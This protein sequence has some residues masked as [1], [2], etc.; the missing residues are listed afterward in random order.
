MNADPFQ[1]IQV[2]RRPLHERIADEMEEM[3]AFHQLAPGT[4][5]PTERE[6]AQRLDV[7]RSTVHQAIGLL[8]QRGLVGMKVGSGTYVTS[9]PASVVA[10]SIQRYFLFASCSIADLIKLRCILEPSTAALAAE[11]ATDEDLARLEDCVRQVEQAYATRD[12][13][14]YARADTGFHEALAAASHNAL[15]S[16]I[17]KGLHALMCKWLLEHALRDWMEEGPKT[18]R[19]VYD[20]VGARDSNLARQT[21][22]SHMSLTTATLLE[23]QS[24]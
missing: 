4:Q 1:S 23:Q 20:A 3:I 17:S 7:N 6:L 13:E 24:V 11:H 2:S 9:M 15:I 18:H 19:A 10:D 16:A 8:Q 22:E 21:M 5:L 14:L 12:R